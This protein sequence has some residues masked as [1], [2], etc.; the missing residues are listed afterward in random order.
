MRRTASCSGRNKSKSRHSGWGL[1]YLRIPID[2]LRSQNRVVVSGGIGGMDP[3]A[4]FACLAAAF[5]DSLFSVQRQQLQ[6]YSGVHLYLHRSH[7]YWYFF[8]TLTVR[9]R[10][11]LQGTGHSQHPEA[12]PPLQLSQRGFCQGKVTLGIQISLQTTS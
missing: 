1:V 8:R 7:S 6:G 2:L 12:H 9:M 3:L 5:D 11:P 4:E 10:A